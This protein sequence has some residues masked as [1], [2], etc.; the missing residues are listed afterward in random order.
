MPRPL[1][2][3]VQLE[4]LGH[5]PPWDWDPEHKQMTRP[6]ISCSLVCKA[7]CR[8]CQRKLLRNVK[9]WNKEELER[10]VALLSSATH[11]IGTY[12]IQLSLWN[13]LCQI[14]LL[15][16]ATKLPSLRCLDLGSSY[17]RAGPFIIRSSDVMHLKHFRT[18]TELRLY[19][20][21]FQSFWD[22]RR[23]IVA[24]PALS[25]LRLDRISL[26]ESNPSQKP[27]WGIP[28]LFTFP[29]HLTCVTVHNFQDL[30][31]LYMWATPF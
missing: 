1:P 28:S 5:V 24:L 20:V 8:I 9:I 26:V 22:F 19:G 11:P 21:D 4:V 18:V 17:P 7:W 13:D 29:Q 30:N 16:L 12:I 3:N 23:L 2:L 25:T 14:A 27:N 6:L 31:L 10:L 15:Y